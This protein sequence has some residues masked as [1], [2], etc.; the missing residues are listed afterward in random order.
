METTKR[1]GSKKALV[2]AGIGVVGVGALAIAAVAIILVLAIA[3]AL[4]AHFLTP[5]VFSDFFSYP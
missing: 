2:I 1:K 3:L 4:G 5:V